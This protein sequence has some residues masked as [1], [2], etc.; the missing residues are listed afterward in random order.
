MAAFGV[1]SGGADRMIRLWD[2]LTWAEVAEPVAGGRRVMM[3][4]VV[5]LAGMGPVVCALR[6]DGSVHRHDLLT[7]E[8]TGPPVR[9][10]W[11]PPRTPMPRRN[12]SS[13]AFPYAYVITANDA[14]IITLNVRAHLARLSR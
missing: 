2:P 1:V 8:M 12:T 10:G 9:T 7:G 5:Q 14:A 6:A 13:G 3:L 4:C 11:Q